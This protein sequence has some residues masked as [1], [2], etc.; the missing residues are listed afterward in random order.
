[1][2]DTVGG[3]T[4]VYT[5]HTSHTLLHVRALGV[6]FALSGQGKTFRPARNAGAQGPLVRLDSWRTVGAVVSAEW[7]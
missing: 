4:R 7:K 3:G 1:M 6:A 2:S 5:P